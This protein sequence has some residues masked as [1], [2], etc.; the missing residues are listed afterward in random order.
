[1]LEISSPVFEMAD[2]R[3]FLGMRPSSAWHPDRGT[4]APSGRS[5]PCASGRPWPTDYD[6]PGSNAVSSVAHDAALGENAV[7]SR[8]V[9]NLRWHIVPRMNGGDPYA[10][11]EQMPFS[12]LLRPCNATWKESLWSSRLRGDFAAYP[13]AIR[14][15]ALTPMRRLSGGR[16]P[17]DER[18]VEC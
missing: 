15:P 5:V 4:V 18:R 9:S 7:Q 16:L 3:R 6:H 10:V 1:M 12:G 17:G 8:A 11:R 14:L 2:R 13:N